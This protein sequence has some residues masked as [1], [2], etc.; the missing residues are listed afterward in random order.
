MI[1][2]GIDAGC[3]P[4]LCDF[5]RIFRYVSG[6]FAGHRHDVIGDQIAKFIDRDWQ[7][8]FPAAQNIVDFVNGAEL[9]RVDGGGEDGGGFFQIIE[10]SFNVVAML[11][12]IGDH[13]LLFQLVNVIENFRQAR[14][15]LG[16]LFQLVFNLVIALSRLDQKHIANR[17]K[18]YDK[19][20]SD[21]K[22]PDNQIFNFGELNLG[23]FFPHAGIYTQRCVFSD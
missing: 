14:R 21:C 18:P 20:L 16:G 2:Y 19:S 8:A 4:K 15:L 1:H 23:C 11:H 6:D 22:S 7:T 5:E 12:R 13:H 9:A 17:D 3:D 10:Q